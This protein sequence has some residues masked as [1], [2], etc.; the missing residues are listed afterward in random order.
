MPALPLVSVVV[1]TLNSAQF[2]RQTLDSLACQPEVPL[3]VVVVDGGSADGTVPILRAAEDQLPLRWVS[4]P[5]RGQADAINKGFAMASGGVLCWL[6]ADDTLLPGALAKVAAQFDRDPSLDMLSG[7]GILADPVGNFVRVIPET[8]IQV[9]DDL[10]RFGCHICQPSTFLR[11]RVIE[12]HGPLDTS[13]HYAL[14]F[15]N[16]LRIGRHVTYRFVPEIFSTF[17]LHPASK[18]VALQERFWSEEWRAFRT[19]GGTW[20]SPFLLAHL[21][22]TRL[23][24]ALYLA[25]APLRAVL[26]PLFGLRRG[27]WLAPGPPPVLAHQA[28]TPTPR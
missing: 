10:Y 18:T 12:R 16:W 24:W 7:L 3:E 2:L 11:R 17:R 28:K 4:E 25:A 20:R 14:D 13:Y 1:P 6:N 8:P 21:H 22:N 15:E 19:H 9:M 27:E 5:D 23:R 26:W